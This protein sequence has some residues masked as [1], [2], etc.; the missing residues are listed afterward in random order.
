MF[1]PKKAK[2]LCLIVPTLSVFTSRPSEKLYNRTRIDKNIQRSKETRE[3]YIGT[4]NYNCQDTFVLKY[5][6]K[7]FNY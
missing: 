6:F 1:A 3:T 2:E 4:V 7:E 5:R